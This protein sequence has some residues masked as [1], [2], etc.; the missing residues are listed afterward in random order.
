MIYIL[1]IKNF[2]VIFYMFI[3]IIIILSKCKYNKIIQYIIKKTL[4]L[5]FLFYYM[6]KL[7]TFKIN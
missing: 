4:K 6:L 7:K 2:N 5:I 1:N 3:F